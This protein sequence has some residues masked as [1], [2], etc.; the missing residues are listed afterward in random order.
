MVRRD[1]DRTRHFVGDLYQRVIGPT[2][3]TLEERF[4]VQ[5]GGRLIGEI[6]RADGAERTLYAHTCSCSR[7][8]R[9]FGSRPSMGLVM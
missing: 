7:Q 6:V 1:S 2:G 9:D 8:T 5:A 4:R 3:D